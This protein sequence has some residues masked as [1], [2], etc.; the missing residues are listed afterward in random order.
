MG[1]DKDLTAK[2]P[3]EW[4][5][6]DIDSLK[7][8]YNRIHFTHFKSAGRRL[9]RTKPPTHKWVMIGPGK[10]KRVKIE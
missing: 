1:L 7:R 5:Q 2:R 4:T 3:G 10:Y 9:K 8:K 6:D